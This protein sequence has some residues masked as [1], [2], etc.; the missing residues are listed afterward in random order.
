MLSVG[1]VIEMIMITIENMYMVLIVDP[2]AVNPCSRSMISWK[3][4]LNLRELK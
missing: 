3:I 4:K 1:K 2:A